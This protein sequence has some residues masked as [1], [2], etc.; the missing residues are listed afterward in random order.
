MKRKLYITFLTVAVILFGLYAFGLIKDK[1][2]GE[3]NSFYKNIANNSQAE[4]KVTGMTCISCVEKIEGA[5]KKVKGTKSPKV[6]LA[7]GRAA[8]FFDPGVTSA[9]SFV[10]AV[11]RIGKYHAS[12]IRIKS[13]DDLLKEE[14]ERIKISKQFA[15]NIDGKKITNKEFEATLNERL[16]SFR[17][18]GI[19]PYPSA[20]QRYQMVAEVA[21]SLIV[22]TLIQKEIGGENISASDEEVNAEIEGIKKYYRL[23]DK[24]LEDSL[25]AQGLDCDR[26][27]EEVKKELKIKKYLETKVFP[28]KTPEPKKNSLYQ[29][30]LSDIQDKADIKIYSSEILEALDNDSASSRCGGSCC[31]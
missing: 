25:K 8:V 27:K 11:N 6:S 17:K 10:E 15:M 16:Q 31:S 5:L 18:T 24:G 19:N 1:R 4:L 23:N 9:S 21:N 3:G 29:R 22:E 14:Q 13:S 26:L 30:W 28:P 20:K 12:L 7:K 2:E